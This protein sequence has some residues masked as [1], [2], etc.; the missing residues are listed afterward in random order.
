MGGRIRT[1]VSD[2]ERIYKLVRW[3]SILWSGIMAYVFVNNFEW[4]DILMFVIRGLIIWGIGMLICRHPL[5]HI[6]DELAFFEKGVKLNNIEM[7]F[8]HYSEVNFRYSKIYTDGMLGS[9]NSPVWRK[10]IKEFIIH[11]SD[12]Y[13]ITYLDKAEACFINTYMKVGR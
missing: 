3:R 5:R 4:D 7:P 2:K 11:F 12:K 10:K 6:N 13:E 9:E 1:I 8:E